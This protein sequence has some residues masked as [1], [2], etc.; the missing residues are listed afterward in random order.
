MKYGKLLAIGGLATLLPL[1]AIQAAVWRAVA[2]KN[3]E[4]VELW[5][6]DGI[7]YPV[8]GSRFT[9]SLLNQELLVAGRLIPVGPLR[10]GQ[11]RRVVITRAIPW[12]P[13]TGGVQ[14]RP[15]QRN[16]YAK[17]A[18]TLP[19]TELKPE[20]LLTLELP[21]LGNSASSGGSA[22]IK[23]CVSLPADY[24]RATPH[25]VIIHFGGG[26]GG[27][28]DWQHWRRITGP[29]NFIIVTA[30]YNHDENEKKGLL[31]IGTCRDF[32]SKIAFHALQI[33]RNST[34]TDPKTVILTG[35]SSGAY[36]ITDNLKNN[37]KAWQPFSGFCAIAGGSK[38]G[39][40]RIADRP[41][42]FI[43]G[44]N[45]TMR[46]KWLDEAV[47]GLKRNRPEKLFVEKVPGV[48]HDWPEAFTPLIRKW[49]ENFPAYGTSARLDAMTREAP[50]DSVRTIVESWKQ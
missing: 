2:V 7:R 33:L 37:P 42:L 27:T 31:K 44:A 15:E 30:D 46:H 32:N 14:F 35:F 8:S 9:D 45:D 6:S 21:E 4:T 24:K 3:G 22:P 36:S 18:R 38:A 1:S 49:L 34:M 5:T 40:A 12:Q 39:S 29:E 26:T 48:G 20:A 16:T 41:T 28:G 11:V 13:P 10:E 43:I 23:M 17:T 50:D 47:D 19:E 25:P